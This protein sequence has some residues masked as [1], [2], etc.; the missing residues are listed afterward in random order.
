MLYLCISNHLKFSNMKKLLLFT[1]LVAVASM[2]T[3][4]ENTNNKTAQDM[5]GTWEGSTYFGDEEY[6]ADYQF[7]PDAESN[8]GK[9]LEIDYLSITDEVGEE[10]YDMPYLAYVGGTYTVKDGSLYLNYD[11][12]TAWVWFDEDPVIDY[13]DAFLA[14]DLEYGEG[15]WQEFEAQDLV[16]YFIE[17]RTEDL[18][19]TWEEIITNFNSGMSNG[20]GQLKVTETQLSYHTSDLGELVFTKAAEDLFDEYPF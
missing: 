15:E 9:F 17:S 2:F 1:M 20:Y 8:T 6:P 4:C 10:I 11:T 16:D 14:Y 12:E 19:S 13:V 18:G 5:K 3:A 7:F